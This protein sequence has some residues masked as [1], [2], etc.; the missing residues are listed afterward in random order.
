MCIA[1]STGTFVDHFYGVR[2]LRGRFAKRTRYEAL[3]GQDYSDDIVAEASELAGYTSILCSGWRWHDLFVYDL[4]D[5]MGDLRH[6]F[7]QLGCD[8]NLLR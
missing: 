6:L 4:F 5:M 2:S 3:F 7:T 8:D 1:S